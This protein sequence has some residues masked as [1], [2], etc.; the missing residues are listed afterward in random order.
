MPKLRESFQNANINLTNI[1]VEVSVNQ[2]KEHKNGQNQQSQQNFVAKEQQ[3]EVVKP[4]LSPN[5]SPQLLN[6]IID[7]YI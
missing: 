6:S 1:Q 2:E 5:T 3:G 7:A 4:K